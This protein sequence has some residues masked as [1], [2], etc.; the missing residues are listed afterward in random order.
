MADDDLHQAIQVATTALCDQHPAIGLSDPWAQ[1]ARIAVGAAWPHA[2]GVI[3]NARNKVDRQREAN[4]AMQRQADDARAT[5]RG[6]MRKQLDLQQELQ[7]T[8]DRHADLEV[9]A[10]ELRDL[11]EDACVFVGRWEGHPDAAELANR[12]GTTLQVDGPARGH[13]I[14][15]EVQRLRDRVRREPCE[16]CYER[17]C[18][19]GDQCQCHMWPWDALDQAAQREVGGGGDA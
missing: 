14:L 15:T 9:Y 12:I 13:T 3:A 1:V 8:R 5:A 4:A 11:L 10:A 6:A 7:A 2:E 16:D 19:S 18:G 17:C